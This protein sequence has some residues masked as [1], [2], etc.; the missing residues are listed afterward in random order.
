MYSF[1]G[2]VLKLNQQFIILSIL[3]T[4]TL[5]FT[6]VRFVHELQIFIKTIEWI[7]VI[8]KIIDY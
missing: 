3:N 2:Y 7:T 4:F 6:I 1:S 8:P 5:Y